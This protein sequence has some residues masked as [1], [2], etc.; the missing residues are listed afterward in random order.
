MTEA[1]ALIKF[2]D[3]VA[4][5]E[6]G[7]FK[8]TYRSLEVIQTPRGERSVSTAIYY[9]LKEGQSSKLHRIQSDEVWHFYQGDPLIVFEREEDGTIKKTVLGKDFKQGQKVQY[10]VPAGRWFGAYLPQGSE[11]AFVGCTVAPGF[12][13][14]DFELFD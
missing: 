3:L 14:Q 9:L 7:F 12:D 2:H 5:P 4:H 11:Y 8:E 10:T 1:D 13:F 6:G